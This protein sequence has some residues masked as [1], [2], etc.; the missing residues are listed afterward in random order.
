VAKLVADD[1]LRMRALGV[2]PLAPVLT[3]VHW[4]ML[5]AVADG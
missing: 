2:S 5:A 3:D 1:R 4:R